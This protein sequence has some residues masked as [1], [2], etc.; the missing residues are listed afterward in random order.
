MKRAHDDFILNTMTSSCLLSAG[1]YEVRVRL[2]EQA[3]V[4]AMASQGVVTYML[5]VEV[6]ICDQDESF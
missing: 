5:P 6:L 1:N 2:D 4:I 3:K